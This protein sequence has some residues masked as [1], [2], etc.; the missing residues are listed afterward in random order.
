M[1]D[2]E[3]GTTERPFHLKVGISIMYL[4]P[5][6]RKVAPYELADHPFRQYSR[7]THETPLLDRMS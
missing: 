6:P 2:F 5:K 3:G 7:D 1:S 4:L